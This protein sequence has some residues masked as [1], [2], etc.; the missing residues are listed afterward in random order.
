MNWLRRHALPLL[1]A[2]TIL[3][4]TSCQLPEGQKLADK[5][6]K[7]YTSG[8]YQQAVEQLKSGL[9][10]GVYPT[11]ESDLWTILGNSY[12]ELDQYEQAIEAHKKALELDP[13]SFKAW[14]NLGAAYRHSDNYDEA[15]KSYQKALELNPDY[16]E[17]Y[18]SL[19]ALYIFEDEP[20]MAVESLEKALK[21]DDTL[22]VSHANI[23]VAYAKLGRFDDAEKALAKANSLGYANGDVIQGMI[24]QEKAAR[25]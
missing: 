24:D 22:P 1:V 15:R 6:V 11:Q 14:T 19:G 7:S 5:G 8:Q 17:A 21:L 4:F 23:A 16:A 9:K 2:L 18:A 25:G 10:A 3:F 20:K 12:D 13:E